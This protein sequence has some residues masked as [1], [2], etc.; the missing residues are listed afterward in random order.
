MA[1]EKYTWQTGEVITADKLNHI[2]GG[3]RSQFSE[4]GSNLVYN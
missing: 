4:I 2:E 1:Y 3:G